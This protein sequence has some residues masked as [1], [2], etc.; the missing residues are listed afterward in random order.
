M[1]PKIIHYT[2]FSGEPFPEKIEQCINSWYRFMP[3]YE[4]VLWDTERIKEIDSPWLNECLSKRKWAYAADMVRMYAV[5]KYGGIYLDTDCEVYRSFD[6]LLE[7]PFFI[8]KENSVHIEGGRIE[9]YLSSHCFGAEQGNEYAERCYRFYASRHFVLSDD[10][11]L[12]MPLK[13]DIILAP[14]VQSELA[15]QVGYNPF[16]SSQNIQRLQGLTIFPERYFDAM[17]SHT[18]N[19]CKHLALGSWREEKLPTENITLGYKIRWRIEAV[20]RKFLDNC[21]YMMIKKM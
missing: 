12:P 14:F 2:W 7:E 3:E 19:Y 9:H 13:W 5:Y 1:I 8:G 4:Y 21:G 11:T 17:K 18:D 6:A 20:V 10:E 15:K 16:P